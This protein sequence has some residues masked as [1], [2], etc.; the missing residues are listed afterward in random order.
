MKRA[1]SRHGRILAFLAAISVFAWMVSVARLKS[2][3]GF[4]Y[5]LWN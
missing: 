3:W 2:P 1:E 4:L 5:Y